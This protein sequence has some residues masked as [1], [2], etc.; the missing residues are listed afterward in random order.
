MEITYS[1]LSPFSGSTSAA[2]GDAASSLRDLLRQIRADLTTS[3]SLGARQEASLHQ[4]HEVL[5]DCG[6]SDWDGY[7][8]EPI[9]LESYERARLL[10]L[11][12]PL[13]MQQ[14]AISA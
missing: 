8:A 6:S 11:S 9:S 10:I 7:D 2:V 13:D 12:L 14:P 1:Y 5:R 4:L 3:F